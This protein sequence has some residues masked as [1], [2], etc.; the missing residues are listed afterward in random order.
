MKILYTQFIFS[1]KVYF[2]FSFK[3]VRLSLSKSRVPTWPVQSQGHPRREPFIKKRVAWSRRRQLV[4]VC[5]HFMSLSALTWTSYNLHSVTILFISWLLSDTRA[6]LTDKQR[7][8]L[9]IHPFRIYWSYEWLVTTV[10][11]WTLTWTVFVVETF[12]THW[13]FLLCG[14]PEW[15]ISAEA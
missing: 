13:S 6:S 5:A 8:I 4:I 10:L 11:I 14:I 9:S 7:G 3:L 1:D 12:R 15:H 2:E